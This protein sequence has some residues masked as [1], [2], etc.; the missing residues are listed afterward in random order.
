MVNQWI[1]HVKEFSKKHNIAYGC[2]VSNPKC[3]EEYQNKKGSIKKQEPTKKPIDDYDDISNKLQQVIFITPL[4]K[5][6]SALLKLNYK[7][8]I[9]TNKVLMNMQILQNFK[10]I[11][12]MKEL[13]KQLS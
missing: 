12:K 8:K 13:L 7:G 1:T 10:S 11:E 6:R 5:I 4:D 3:K 9:Q 2:A